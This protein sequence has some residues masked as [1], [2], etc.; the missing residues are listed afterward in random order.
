MIPNYQFAYSL[1][2]LILASFLD[3]NLKRGV[4][5]SR[6]KLNGTAGDSK[7]TTSFCMF[8][9]PA[10]C[11]R[12][13]TL[14]RRLPR[15]VP[16]TQVQTWVNLR[17]TNSS[18]LK[19]RPCPKNEFSSFSFVDEFTAPFSPN[20]KHTRLNHF[21]FG[22]ISTSRKVAARQNSRGKSWWLSRLVPLFKLWKRSW[23]LAFFTNNPN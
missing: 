1:V 2:G 13:A 22:E 5:I 17:E 11:P 23:K 18:P 20:L 15:C 6:L 14:W 12:R 3:T 19:I 21:F 8:F 10:V 4:L 7:Y 16:N 9:L